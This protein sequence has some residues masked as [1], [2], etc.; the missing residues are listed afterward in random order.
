MSISKM[1]RLE[2]QQRSYLCA[3]TLVF[4]IHTVDLKPTITQSPDTVGSL[5]PATL[6]RGIRG[7]G[8]DTRRPSALF[9]AVSRAIADAGPLF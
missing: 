5:F 4:G 3:M 8:H 7:F 2:D 6:R 9:V 1:S